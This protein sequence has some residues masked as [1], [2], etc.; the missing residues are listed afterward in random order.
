[1]ASAIACCFLQ[2]I[3]VTDVFKDYICPP[4]LAAL[5]VV[6]TVSERRARE[7]TEV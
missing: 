4:Y 7:V 2:Q 3:F 5:L 6:T 1:M